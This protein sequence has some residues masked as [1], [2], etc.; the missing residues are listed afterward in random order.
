VVRII[1]EGKRY[2]EGTAVRMDVTGENDIAAVVMLAGI[3]LQF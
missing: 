1:E 2:P 3:K